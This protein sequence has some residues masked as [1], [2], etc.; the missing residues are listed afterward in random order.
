MYVHDVFDIT[1]IGSDLIIHCL[2]KKSQPPGKRGAV[3]SW[4]ALR[5]LVGVVYKV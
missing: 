3:N 2:A 1:G 4:D 5:I